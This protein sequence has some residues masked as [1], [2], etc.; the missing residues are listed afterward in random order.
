[1]LNPCIA[2]TSSALTWCGRFAG[3][4]WSPTHRFF[5]ATVAHIRMH[6]GRFRSWPM[7]V[8]PR[9]SA[10][11]WPLI[12]M[13]E[14]AAASLQVRRGAS[15]MLVF[16]GP[17]SFAKG[18]GTPSCVYAASLQCRVSA[19]WNGSMGRTDEGSLTNWK[20]NVGICCEMFK[21][22]CMNFEMC[23]RQAN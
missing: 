12:S 2:F 4:C 10:W 11:P 19:T 23:S 15:R 16:L 3:C 18:S 13:L 1:M 22:L 14:E 20:C 8:F 7:A 9:R 21:W 6:P 5:V 17:S